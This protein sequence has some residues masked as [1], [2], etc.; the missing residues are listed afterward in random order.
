M[1][2]RKIFLGTLVV[3]AI[4]GYT[5]VWL[6]SRF[7]LDNSVY[8]GKYAYLDANIFVSVLLI[9]IAVL[10]YIAMRS[11]SVPIK[12]LTK[13]IQ[14]FSKNNE[15]VPVEISFTT[16]HDVRLL[17]LSFM[18]LADRVD[19]ARKRDVEVSRIKSDFIST[20][21]HQ[22]RTPLTSIRWALEALQKEELSDDDK[23]LVTTA[24]EK[25]KELVA[26][27]STLLDTSNIE[28]GKY[29]YKFIQT[30]IQ[31]L[32]AKVVD[33]LQYMADKREI[34]LQYR[35][36]SEVLPSVRVDKERIT[37]IF[38]N[39]IE[40]ALKYTPK[41]GHVDVWAEVSDTNK[42]LVRVHDTGIGVPEIDRPDIFGRFYRAENAIAKENEGNGLGLYIARSV[43]K[44]HGGNLSFESN[45]EGVGTTFTL[46]LPIVT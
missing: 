46:S 30:N 4:S 25:S 36:Y 17:I 43:A 38:N 20:A 31:S 34:K 12:E 11:V 28:A 3:F 10:F 9:V 44:D 39:L 40:N 1:S 26:I 7:V 8:V 41:G 18:E 16:P 2:L 37:W 13:A 33:G 35:S 29:K 21:A 6:Y 42:M 19:R 14:A 5:T 32:L 23:L 22:L 27:V 45:T 24:V 15:H